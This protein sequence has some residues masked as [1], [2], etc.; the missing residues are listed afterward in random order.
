MSRTTHLVVLRYDQ[1]TKPKNPSLEGA[2][3]NTK[4]IKKLLNEIITKNS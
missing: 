4:S 1:E 2:E 3:I